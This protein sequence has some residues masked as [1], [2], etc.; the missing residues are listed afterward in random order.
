MVINKNIE[1]V[2]CRTKFRLRWQIGYNK[3]SVQIRCPTCNTRIF[4]YLIAEKNNSVNLKG[5]VET[6]DHKIDYVQEISTE[7]LTYKLCPVKEYTEFITPFMRNTDIDYNKYFFYYNFIIDYPNEVEAINDLINN[8]SSK[9]LK[10]KLHDNDNNNEFIR[11]CKMQIKNYRLN[12]KVDLLMAS[13]QYLMNAFF[14]SGIQK[15]ILNIAKD[16][17]NL[18]KNKNEQVK[19]FSKLL[20]NNG[21]YCGLNSKFAK[22]ANIYNKNYLALVSTIAFN[23]WENIDKTQFGLSS[24][25]YE[26]LLELYRKCYEFIGEYII[27]IISLNNI[28]ERHDFNE[29]KNG[30]QDIERKVNRE[31]KYNR[32]QCFVKS[33]EHFSIGFCD[34]LN[35]I[36]RNSESH[37]DVEYNIMTQEITFISKGRN[38]TEIEKMYL[39][40][41]TNETIKIFSLCVSLW[42]IAYQLQKLRLIYDLNSRLSYGNQ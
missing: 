1:C 5:A 36:I 19:E 26:E 17:S 16:L 9:F 7:F 28:Y 11:I 14:V 39:L 10:E 20:D 37:F 22:L 21:Y 2:G 33:D 4:G 13:H 27:Y 29:F 6:T 41:F 31:D 35:K 34:T 32:I 15:N 38:K 42:E 12:S 3:A 8:K 40:D 23:D 18:R 30:Y 25:D 24:V